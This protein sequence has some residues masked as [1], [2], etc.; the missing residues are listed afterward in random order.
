MKNVNS[1]NYL[2]F[3]GRKKRGKLKNKILIRSSDGS[4]GKSRRSTDVPVELR[5]ILKLKQRTW[6][7]KL[8]KSAE[9]CVG[10][11]SS[12]FSFINRNSTQKVN[13]PW[14]CSSCALIHSIGSG[15]LMVFAYHGSQGI[16]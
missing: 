10:N 11:L 3:P 6:H 5:N 2:N 4:T 16:N 12:A 7:Q 8:N 1:E 13:N 15:S 14:L 9:D